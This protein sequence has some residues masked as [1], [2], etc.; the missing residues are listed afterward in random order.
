MTAMLET[1]NRMSPEE[2]RDITEQIRRTAD[3]LWRL[4]LDA[5]DRRAWEVLGYSSFREYAKAE[6]SISQS[7]AYQLVDQGR[8]IRALEAAAGDS[9]MVEI[10]EREAR[11][12]KPHLELVTRAIQNRIADGEPP[13]VAIQSVRQLPTPPDQKYV[14]SRKRVDLPNRIMANVVAQSKYGFDDLLNN[15]ETPMDLSAL[16]VACIPGWISDLRETAKMIARL[17][18]KLEREAQRR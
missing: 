18:A 10:S 13:N 2:A 14:L 5:H 8:V 12:L 4:M 17:I 6:F 7:R 3:H 15:D 16:D 11:R 9:T 1:S